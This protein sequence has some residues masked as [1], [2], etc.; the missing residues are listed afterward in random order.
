MLVL[1][2]NHPLL[3]W[4]NGKCFSTVQWY[5]EAAMGN[6]ALDLFVLFC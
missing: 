2:F 6:K 5:P 1:E 4:N 3:F